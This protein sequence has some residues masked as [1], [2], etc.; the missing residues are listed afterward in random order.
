MTE[1]EGT[2][3]SKENVTIMGLVGQVA[4]VGQDVARIDFDELRREG[5]PRPHAH[6]SHRGWQQSADNRGVGRCGVRARQGQAARP[7]C[8]AGIIY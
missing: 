7:L 8:E 4:G 5:H 1:S 3:L 6:A 2:L